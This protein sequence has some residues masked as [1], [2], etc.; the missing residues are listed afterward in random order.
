[1]SANTTTETILL[2]QWVTI[3]H[4]EP[5]RQKL[6]QIQ[7]FSAGLYIKKVTVRGM[8]RGGNEVS[9]TILPGVYNEEDNSFLEAPSGLPIMTFLDSIPESLNP[10]PT[11]SVKKNETEEEAA[12]RL[13]RKRAYTKLVKN[14][15]R[16]PV[17]LD[18]MF[19]RQYSKVNQVEK[20][21]DLQKKASRSQFFQAQADLHE[22]LKAFLGEGEW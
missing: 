13:L 5:G 12:Q 15:G 7:E 4:T 22:F 19:Y 6:I 10:F 11:V 20:L 16:I 9:L 17:Y 8:G 2:D 18:E 21:L 3:P 14:V 1:M